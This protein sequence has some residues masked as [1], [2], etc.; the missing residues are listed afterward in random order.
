MAFD[1][2]VKKYLQEYQREYNAAMRGGQHTAELSF[3]VPMHTLFKRI[4][5]DLN[6]SG[7]FDIILEPRNQKRMGRP[8][9]RIQDAVS[10]GVYG[11]IEAKG[12]SADPFDIT[13]YQNQINKYLSLGH[14]LIITDGID[15]VFCFN[16]TPTIVSI[17]DKGLINN[18]DWSRL[19]VNHLFRFYMEQFFSNP[20]AQ[21]VDEEKLVELVAIRTR[22]LADEILAQADLTIDEALSED[23]RHIITLLNGL[24]ELVYNHNDPTLRTGAV[25]SDFIAQVIMFCLLYAHRVLCTSE[26]SPSEKAAKIREYAFNDIVDGEALLPFRNLMV[27][28]RDN[29][30]FGTFIGEWVDECISFL[31]FVQMTDHQLMN[32]DYHRLFEMFLTKFDEKSRFDYGAYYTPKVLADFIVRL[33]NWVVRDKFDGASIY[34]NGNTII[35]PCCG[36]GSFLERIIAHD[37][38]DGAYNLCGFEILPAPYMLANYRMA[39]VERQYGKRNLDI[40]VLLANTL[41]NCLLGEEANPASI[42]GRELIRANELSSR[43]IKL[44]IGNPPCSDSIRSNVAGDFS[45]ISELMDDFRPPVEGRRNRQ[46]IQKQINNP[47]MQFL[48]WSCKKLLDSGCHAALALIVPLSFLET[49][50]YKYARKYLVEHF[51]NIWAVSIDTDARTGIRG[52]SLFCTMQGRA[53]ILLTRKYGVNTHINEINY[54]D[55]SRGRRTEKIAALESDIPTIMQ[56]FETFPVSNEMYSFLPSKSFN[57]EMY[58]RFWPIS[59][60]SGKAVFLNQCSGAKMAPT[61]LLTHVKQSILK[62]RS[63]EIANDGIVKAKEWIGR[64]DKHV[65]DAK[66]VAFKNALNTCTSRQQLDSMLEE[67]ICPCSFRP[68]V[69]SNVLLWDTVFE[70]QAGVGGGGARIRPEIKAVY[71]RD[72]TIGFSLAHAPKDLDESLGQF[73]SFCWYFPDN[74]LS[75]RGNGHIYLNQYISDTRTKKIVNNIHSEL[76]DHLILLTGLSEYECSRKMVFYAY[77]IF[78]S[79]VYLEEFFGALYVVNQSESRARIPIIATSDAFLRLSMLGEQM[80]NLEKNG[81]KVENV[82]NLDYNALLNQLP[83][84]FKL[85]HSKAVTKNP[86]DEEHE[87]LVL[88]GENSNTEI[89]V[90]CPVEIQKFTVS[91]YNVIKDCWLK[92]HSFRYTHCEFTQDDFRDLLDLLNK[93][94]KQMQYV[95]EVDEV[96]H[97]IVNGEIPLLSY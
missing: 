1:A 71:E 43:P 66:I 20:T 28:L 53:V 15:F 35:D 62:R 42:E 79:Q 13:P 10:L 67:N 9:W 25:F 2:D 54:I 70:Y 84:G 45:R 94:A 34:D 31:S 72:D 3:R 83:K 23:E 7:N 80:A 74:D 19:P 75:R 60:D 89:T 85:E 40:S 47:F 5:H 49:E 33:T 76:I 77:A 11:Y 17:I 46:N 30:G 65:V 44:I 81:V 32:P 92:F 12:P 8:D 63:R 50:S 51:S 14:K 78:C 39:I 16:D 59:N 90:Y 56:S 37:V 91:G 82:L 36:T 55:M 4:A 29:S 95:S 87:N 6:P 22:N 64:Q 48:R 73:T 57:K 61:A 68:F 26:D 27:Y 86:Y 52:D 38:G 41:S 24:K 69:N 18:T 97:G 21:R 96:V 93:I 58:A 88:R